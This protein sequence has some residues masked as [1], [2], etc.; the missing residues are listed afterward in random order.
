M[1]DLEKRIAEVSKAHRPFW[2]E[3]ED[4][5]LHCM[6]GHFTAPNGDAATSAWGDHL[7]TELAS[8]IREAQAEAW[9]CAKAELRSIPCW[10]ESAERNGFDLCEDADGN[11]SETGSRILV[12]KIMDNNPYRSND[13]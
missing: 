5:K 10:Y 7:A 13:E 1:S 8:V 9:E 4:E 3:V 11:A 2:N 12:M 6:C